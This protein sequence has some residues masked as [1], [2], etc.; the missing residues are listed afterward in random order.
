MYSLMKS[1]MW[2]RHHWVKE[3]LVSLFLMLSFHCDYKQL[4]E[5]Y[6]DPQMAA[7]DVCYGREPSKI[8]ET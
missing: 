1:M 7:W 8:P 5:D 3:I 4:I 6:I 2:M